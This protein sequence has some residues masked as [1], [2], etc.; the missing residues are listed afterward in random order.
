MFVRRSVLG[1]RASRSV[2]LVL[3]GG[4]P[5]TYLEMSEDANDN[6]DDDD[7]DDDD[8]VDD[9]RGAGAQEAR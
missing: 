6:D 3:P 4:T 9:Q 2:R 8:D 5:E 1:R 7:D